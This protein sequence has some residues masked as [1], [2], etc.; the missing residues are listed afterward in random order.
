[1]QYT[2]N[3]GEL[4]GEDARRDCVH[5]AMAPVVAGEDM[6]PG[7]RVRLDQEGKGYEQSEGSIGIVDPF[8]DDC[9]LKGQKFWLFLYPNTITNLRHVWSHPA[10]QAKLPIV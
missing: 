9:V 7:A 10:F 4:C 5:I 1:M 6:N 8:L 3:I 2:P